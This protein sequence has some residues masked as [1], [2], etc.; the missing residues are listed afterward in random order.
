MSLSMYEACVPVLVHALSNLSHILDK[1][2]ASANARKI[3]P[4]VLLGARLAPDM[5]PLLRQV[6]IASDTAKGAATRLAGHEV[7]RYE[8]TET[9]FEELQARIQKTLDLIR[10]IPAADFEGA[11]E[12]IVTLKL[13]GNDVSFSG[14]AYLFNFALPNL[15]FHITTAYDLLR[16]NGV[17]LGKLDYLGALPGP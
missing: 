9:S 14:R 16:H 4:G 2:L 6:H 10:S 11:E 3:E 7:P 8:D 17:E 1:G 5:L 12:R 15:Y 13:R